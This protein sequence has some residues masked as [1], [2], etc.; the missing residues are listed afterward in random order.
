MFIHQNYLEIQ[1]GNSKIYCSIKFLPSI[2]RFSNPNLDVMVWI[3]GGGFQ[4]GS[5]NAFLYGPDYLIP[6]NV[7]VVTFNYRLGN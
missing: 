3:H 4:F 5:G 1:L 6:E 2:K 7:I